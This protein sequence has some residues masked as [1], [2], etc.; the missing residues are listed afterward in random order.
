MF[1]IFLQEMPDGQKTNRDLGDCEG[2]AENGADTGERCVDTG[3]RNI[4]A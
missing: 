4:R 2:Q 3:Q 1:F